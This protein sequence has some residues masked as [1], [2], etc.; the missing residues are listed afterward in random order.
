MTSDGRINISVH[1]ST[2]Q[3]LAELGGKDDTFNDIILNL[4]RFYED[5]K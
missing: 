3:K 5:N 1:R 4:I 2:R